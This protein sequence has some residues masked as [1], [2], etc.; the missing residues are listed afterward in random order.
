VAQHSPALLALGS[1]VRDFRGRL[2]LSQ[3]ELAHRAELNRTYVGDVERGTR[4]VSFNALR[5]IADGLEIRL[6]EL[7]ARGEDLESRTAS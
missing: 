4:N 3:E 7:L 2:G 1:A 6:S 5:R